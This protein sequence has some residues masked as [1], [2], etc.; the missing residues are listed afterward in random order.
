MQAKR[1]I[2][3]IWLANIEYKDGQYTGVVDNVPLSIKNVKMGDT[4][5]ISNA[6]ITDWF[7]IEDGKLYGGY[8]IRVLRD[9][10]S[11]KE[12]RQFDENFPVTY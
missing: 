1:K 12:R 2:E 8:T 6:D 9:K 4:L 10:M 11:E 5:N 7:Y 3:H